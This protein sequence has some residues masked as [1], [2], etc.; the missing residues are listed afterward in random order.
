MLPQWAKFKLEMQ[1]DKEIFEYGG[2]HFKPVRQFRKGEIDKH[3]E[4]DS[5][6][7]K[8]DISYASRN[9]RFGNELGLRE[10]NN[11]WSYEAFYAAAN[12]SEADIFKC[13]ENG[14]L[15]VPSASALCQYSEPPQ[16]DKTPSRPADKKP[17]IMDR[18][19][20]MKAEVAKQNAERKNKP[21]P[22]KKRGDMEVN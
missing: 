3:L 16:R 20:D 6:P 14:K 10:Q 4:G 21:T 8:K 1:R 17:A 9:M 7:W 12:G 2:Y 13:I 19:D 22:G 5:R 18:L 11:N 15:F